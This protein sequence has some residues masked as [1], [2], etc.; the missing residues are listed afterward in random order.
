MPAGS[1][2]QTDW[3]GGSPGRPVRPPTISRLP[4]PRSQRR[5][6]V[7]D[8]RFSLSQLE[9]WRFTPLKRQQ[10]DASCIL[11]RDMLTWTSS[12]PAPAASACLHLRLRVGLEQPRARNLHPGVGLPHQRRRCQHGL[13]LWRLRSLHIH[14]MLGLSRPVG[15]TA[16]RVQRQGARTICWYVPSH[17]CPW[18]FS[19][20]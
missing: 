20:T 13:P 4:L 11:T 19:A 6:R 10:S 17:Q 3:L 2:H 7:V 18:D 5:L 8:R 9:R 15:L 14:H 1:E 12:G 16:R